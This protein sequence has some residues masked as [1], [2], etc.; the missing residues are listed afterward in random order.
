[1]SFKY[2]L[3]AVIFI[4]CLSTAKAKNEWEIACQAYTFK[5]FTFEEALIKMS[6]L[7]IKE[8]E[9]F[10]KQKM[11]SSDD[12]LTYFTMDEGQ[13]EDL[14]AMLKKYGVKATSYGVVSPDNEADWLTLFEFAKTMGIQTIVSEPKYDQIKMVD[15]LA[16]KFKIRVAIHNHPEPTKYWDPEIVS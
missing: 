16:R 9:I 14:K 3:L 15:E 7:G 5:E 2:L 4:A 8:V 6:E 12:R 13:V 11:S 10:P 1:M